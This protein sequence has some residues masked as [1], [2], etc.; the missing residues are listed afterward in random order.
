MLKKIVFTIKM[1]QYSYL[2]KAKFSSKSEAI[3]YFRLLK[4]T[5]TISFVMYI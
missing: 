4:I 3:F 1:I 2:N 5:F